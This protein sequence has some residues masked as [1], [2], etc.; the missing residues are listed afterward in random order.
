MHIIILKVLCMQ[1]LYLQY[2]ILFK[3]LF[4]VVHPSVRSQFLLS[5]FLRKCRRKLSQISYVCSLRTLFTHIA[6]SDR[7]VNK[8]ADRAPSWNLVIEIIYRLYFSKSYEGI[9]FKLDVQV[10][11][12]PQMCK[13]H[14]GTD[15]S[16]RW[17]T[18]CHLGF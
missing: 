6:F 8:M 7:L 9:C 5:L 16:T 1:H 2:N 4:V 10:S 15:Q 3:L 11:L 13:L 17:R 12:G 14:F 18:G